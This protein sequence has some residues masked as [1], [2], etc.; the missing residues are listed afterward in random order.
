MTMSHD[1]RVRNTVE[2]KDGPTKNRSGGLVGGTC[3][4]PHESIFTTVI[5]MKTQEVK[6]IFRLLI[7]LNVA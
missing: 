3:G 7:S 5:K 1:F 4:V 6:M 2:R